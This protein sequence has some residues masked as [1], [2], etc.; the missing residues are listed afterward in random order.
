MYFI[1]DEEI[2]ALKALFAK[3][4]LFRYQPSGLSE[5]E[6]FEK[7]FSNYCGTKH[8]LLLTSGTNS[9]FLSLLVSGLQP[10]DEVLIPSYTF[11]ATAAAVV[12]AGGIPVI[13]NVDEN[14]SM[15]FKDAQQ[16]ITKKTKALILVHMDG[17]AGNIAEAESLCKLHHLTFIE[18]VAQAIGGS[19]EEKKLG[20]FGHFGCFSLNENKHISCG[21]GGILTTSNDEFFNTAFMLHDTPVQFSPSKKE[22]LLQQVQPYIGHSMRVSEIQGT[23][24]Q[25]QLGRLDHLLNELRERKKIL[26]DSLKNVLKI[27]IPLGYSANGDCGSSLHIQLEDF[28]QSL[29]V[30]KKL[31]EAHISFIPVTARPA[32]ASWKWSHLFSEQ[33]NIQSGRN[34][35]LNSDFRR[36]YTNSDCFSSIEILSRTIKLD[37]DIQLTLS[38]T[39]ELADQIKIILSTV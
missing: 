33:A 10:G 20:S 26:V 36:T 12:M 25:V 14:L 19:F 5:C 39:K 15:D 17:L 30:L 3:K 24:M 18:D 32:H 11:V 22:M 27:K 9:L 38:Q 35:F 6:I 21:E 16:K 2:E 37:L 1:G 4:K 7:K 31:R 23:I 13:V 34:Q 8:S 29:I 28:D